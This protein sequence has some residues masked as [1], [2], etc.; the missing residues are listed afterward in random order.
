MNETKSKIAGNAVDRGTSRLSNIRPLLN[1]MK[2]YN[3]AL[4]DCMK[5]IFER[6]GGYDDLVFWNIA[7]ITGDTITQVYNHN[8]TTGCEYCV[9]GYL[10][11]LEHI[12]YIFGVLGYA[13]E[14]VE[15]GIFDRNKT[16]Y[17]GEITEYIKNNIPVLVRTNLNDIPAWE[18]DV[19]TYC[20]ITGCNQNK[21][22]L[23][24]LTAG[25]IP[26]EY[27]I[28]DENNLDL[29]FIGKKQRDVSTEEIYMK[30]IKKM[31]NW[32]TLPERDGMYFG[33][34]ACRAWAD[35]IENGRFAEEGLPLWENYGVYVCNLATNGD[36]GMFH[37]RKLSELNPKYTNLAKLNAEILRLIPTENPDG[38]G[39]CLLWI[40]LDELGAGMDMDSVRDT[41]R[42]KEK[43]LKAAETLRDHA[44]KLDMAVDLLI[45]AVQ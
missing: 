22:T 7:A 28:K 29:I 11:G 37:L 8:K 2:G 3:Y 18:S 1:G 19:G 34:A 31:P 26:I 17:L 12:A 13:Y 20:L 10:P 21:N 45:A 15:A 33:S 39:K 24:L 23:E 32:L 38:S 14:Y 27:K 43:R 5:F 41:M 40:K 44:A 25:T 9:S 16:Y 30:I 35:D 4:P 6:I 36:L 42:S